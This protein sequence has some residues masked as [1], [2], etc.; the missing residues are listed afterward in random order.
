MAQR[1]SAAFTQRRAFGLH[2]ALVRRGLGSQDDRDAGHALVADEPGLDPVVL[3]VRVRHDRDQPLLDEVDVLDREPGVMHDA[4]LDE[5][6]LFEERPEVGKLIRGQGP[7][8][9][10]AYWCGRSRCHRATFL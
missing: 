3:L 9:L 2:H 6:D 5:R 1:R 10:V 4:L 8:E 7:Q